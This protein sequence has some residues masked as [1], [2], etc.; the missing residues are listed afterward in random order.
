MSTEGPFLY[1]DDPRPR[2]GLLLA[3]GAGTA[4]VAVGAVVLLPMVTGSTQEQVTE[5]ADVFARALAAEDA[6]TAWGLLCEDEQARLRA[7]QVAG[8]YLRPGTPSV[9]DPVEGDLDGQRA[10][11]VP[12]AW[13]D[14]GSVTTVQ[15]V[16]IAQGGAKVCGIA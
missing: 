7:D 3:L 12:V 15:L 16:V 5:V 10:E 9:G 11:V 4:A 6:Q 2:R 13:D 14:G 8:D 1:D